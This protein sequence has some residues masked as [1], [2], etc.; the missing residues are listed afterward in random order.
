MRTDH[1]IYLL[2]VISAA[3]W[4]GSCSAAAGIDPVNKTADGLALRGYDAVA[5]QTVEQAVVGSPEY[6]AVWN[7]AKWFF[8]S[9]ENLE[10]FQQAPESYAPQFG[11]Y[12][13]YA[14]SH[15]YTADGDP[16]EWK[17]VDGKL[18][19]NYNHEA[20]E[21]WEKEQDKFIGLGKE[22]WAEFQRRKPEHRG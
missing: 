18:Y 21:A 8:S 14:V 15:G 20:K 13:S 11:G 22:N 17:L 9:S 5:Y 19:L 1:I 12:C 4:T 3:L 2:L 16:Q 7:G 10:K 6:T